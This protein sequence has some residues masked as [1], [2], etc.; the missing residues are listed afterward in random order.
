MR[1]EHLAD[2]PE[3]VPVVAK[4]HWDEWGHLDP[5]GSLRGWM[6]RLAGRTNRDHIPTTFIAVDEGEPIGSAGLV[7]HDMDTRKDLSPWLSGV[8]VLPSHRSRG[9]ATH[10][11][12]AATSKARSLGVED[13][14]LY[15]ASA[16]ELYARLGWREL[17][18]CRF[19]GRDVT[20]MFKRLDS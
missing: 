17:E 10:L 5:N 2:Q 14:Y 13:L 16:V 18:T 8:F 6:K 7:T 15:T 19:Q 11:V 1:I 3:W 9:V 4:W 12:R 20:I